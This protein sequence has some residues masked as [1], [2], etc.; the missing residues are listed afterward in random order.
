MSALIRDAIHA[1]YGS[2]ASVETVRAALD[3]TFGAIHSDRSGE[4]L[5]DSIR[6]A[7]VGLRIDVTD[8]ADTL[9]LLDHYDS[10]TAERRRARQPTVGAEGLE[11]PTSCL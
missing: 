4:E 6:T 1:T 8:V 2:Y 11:P 5:V 10:D 3:A 9:E 7:S